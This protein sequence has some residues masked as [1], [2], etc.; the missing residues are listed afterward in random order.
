MADHGIAYVPPPRCMSTAVPVPHGLP[1]VDLLDREPLYVHLGK[2]AMVVRSTY[3]SA[4]NLELWVSDNGRTWSLEGAS[5]DEPG[6][7]ESVVQYADAVA[8]GL[9]GVHPHV[10]PYG[11]E[12]GCGR[13]YASHAD[14]AALPD[15]KVGPLTNDPDL[16]GEVW[17]QRLCPCGSHRVWPVS[18]LAWRAAWETMVDRLTRQSTRGFPPKVTR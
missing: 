16:A 10:A 3:T 17:E 18:S 11:Y 9:L 1:K 12:C 5:S 13:L 14:F 4:V 2:R 15:L 6:K 7:L 8:T